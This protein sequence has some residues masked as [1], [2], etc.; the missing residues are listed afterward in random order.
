MPRSP[1]PLRSLPS[2]DGRRGGSDPGRAQSFAPRP[3]QGSRSLRQP[4]RG[5]GWQA[6]RNDSLGELSSPRATTFALAHDDLPID[7]R[8]RES[9]A[10]AVRPLEFQG[11]ETVVFAKTKMGS[12]VA[13][14]AVAVSRQNEPAHPAIAG[15][16]DHLSADGVAHPDQSAHGEPVATRRRRIVAQQ[17]D[18]V[19]SADDQVEVAVPVDVAEGE[20]AVHL[21]EAGK[22]TA[23]NVAD[24]AESATVSILKSRFASP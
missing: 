24:R 5:Q 12:R 6:K 15:L 11:G 13:A 10:T 23:E 16:N 9:L 4:S 3:R 18:T 14:A 17:P 7:T 21:S 8:R 1:V 2:S 20:T 22:G 19:Q